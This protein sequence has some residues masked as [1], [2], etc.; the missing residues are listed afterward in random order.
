MLKKITNLLLIVIIFFP[1]INL[2]SISGSS[3]GIRIEDFLIVVWLFLSLR[4]NFLKKDKRTS[5][6]CKIYLL[7]FCFCLISTFI[8]SFRG[9][10]QFFTGIIYSLRKL[11]YFLF[12]YFGYYYYK[13][14][15]D[16]NRVK[17]ILKF[18]VIYHF[19]IILLQ[20]KGIIGAF[21]MGSFR[22]DISGHRLCSMFNGPYEFSAYLLL[23]LPLFLHQMKE[24]KKNLM[25]ILIIAV[26]TYLSESRTSLVLFLVIIMLYYLKEQKVAIKKVFVVFMS[27][28]IVFFI[29]IN[30]TK[31]LTYLPRFDTLNLHEM[32]TTTKYAWMNRNYE[33]YSQS[34]KY[35]LVSGVNVD[36]SFNARI[37]RD[38]TLL[39]GFLKHPLLGCGLSIVMISA[40]CNYVRLLVECGLI[41]IILYFICLK[42]IYGWVKSK[43]DSLALV[44]KYGIISISL[45]SIF[46]DLFEAS[47][48]MMIFWFIVGLFM[49]CECIKDNMEE[50]N[51]EN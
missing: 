2:I 45:G 20:S 8:G 7:F 22:E 18:S 21:E 9:D 39:D 34:R 49:K 1:K 43:S 51:E 40:D 14:E 13:D 12:V 50:H 23:L 17:R 29:Y 35:Y 24:N 42:K 36:K 5:T 33:L 11:E 6:L 25:Y 32:I 19:I 37:S 28:T 48:I 10:I 4:Y 31:I 46:I 47:K 3:A 16:W 41:G 26:C 30:L 44:I 15:E 38:M 27:M